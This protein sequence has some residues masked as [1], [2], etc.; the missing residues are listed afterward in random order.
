LTLRGCAPADSRS[1]IQEYLNF[2]H[3]EGVQH[4]ALATADIHTTFEAL[5]A[6]GIEFMDVPDAYYEAVDERL[7]G[8]GEDLARGCAGIVF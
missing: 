6:G 8:H 1:Q 3:G 5:R 7:P 4:I 2:Y